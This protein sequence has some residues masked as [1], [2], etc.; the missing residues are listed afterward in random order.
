MKGE[1]WKVKTKKNKNYTF[2]CQQNIKKYANKTPICSFISN[3][4]QMQARQWTH[5][6]GLYLD[7]LFDRHPLMG[8]LHLPDAGSI[9][10]GLF[11][12]SFARKTC[13]IQRHHVTVL[14]VN[15]I[16]IFYMESIINIIPYKMY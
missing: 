2:F 8:F 4:I 12:L 6:N 15:H 1:S 16:S 10:A 9:V 3:K 11:S 7:K 14:P 13:V 5:W